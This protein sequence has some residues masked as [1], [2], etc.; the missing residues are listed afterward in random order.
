M[1]ID[2]C[3]DLHADA[4]VFYQ[5]LD[6]EGNFHFVNW[7]K[8]KNPDSEVL[9]IAGDTS[10]KPETTINIVEEACKHYDLV[11]VVPGNHE[12]YD[13]KL[14]A[15]EMR[16]YFSSTFRCISPNIAFLDG[17]DCSFKF[18]DV[19]FVGGCGW[20]DWKCYEHLGIPE[21]Y[22]Y[23]AWMDMSNDARFVQVGEIHDPDWPGY[24]DEHPMQ[25]L[26]RKQVEDFTKEVQN[27]NSDEGVRTIVVATHTSPLEGLML[28]KPR[29]M[30]WNTLTPSYV[31]SGMNAVWAGEHK[32]SN[33]I[34][35]HTHTPSQKKFDGLPINF[36]NNACGYPGELGK[37][38]KLLQIEV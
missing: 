17:S 6:E 7:K 12:H 1:K 3:S 32:I 19:L 20:Y 38:Y 37:T 30:T 23:H 2:V 8:L 29:D 25:W 21:V 31:N 35:G 15:Q 16:G 28:W 5:E 18:E 22:A 10:N 33:W 27:A 4:W 9:V 14:T 24:K 36:V 34:Y 13:S 26:A 11:V